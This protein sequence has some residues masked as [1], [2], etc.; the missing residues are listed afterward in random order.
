[1]IGDQSGLN[2]I[3][4]CVQ[5][6]QVALVERVRAGNGQGDA[7]QRHRPVVPDAFEHGERP[8]ACIHGILADG[9]EAVAAG[10]T[11]EDIL[12]V[13]AA[14]AYTEAKKRKL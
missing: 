14:Q 13:P 2:A 12:V 4:Q 1:M 5:A 3:D 11:V 9:F 7:V 8:A 10:G 6:A